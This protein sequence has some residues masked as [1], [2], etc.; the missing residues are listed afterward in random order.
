[1]GR[2][3]VPK[4]STLSHEEKVANRRLID[5]REGEASFD[6]FNLTFILSDGTRIP[7]EDVASEISEEEITTI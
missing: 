2:A 1:M 3:R 7:M 5:F 4:T 6:N